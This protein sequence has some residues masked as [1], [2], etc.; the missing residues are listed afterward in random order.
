MGILDGLQTYNARNGAVRDLDQSD[1]DADAAR[2]GSLTING[3]ENPREPRA[4]D[5]RARR[6]AQQRRGVENLNRNRAAVAASGVVVRERE[7]RSYNGRPVGEVRIIRNADDPAQDNQKGLVHVL[8][9]K[10]DAHNAPVADIARAWFLE[11]EATITRGAISDVINRLRANLDGPAGVAP[12][13]PTTPAKK[14]FDKFTDIPTGYYAIR[15]ADDAE[16]I[17]FYRV[18][19]SRDER[20]IR[21]AEMASDTLYPVRPWSR[22]LTILT[23]LRASGPRDAALLF[24]QT[25]G[26]CCRCNRTLTDANSRANGIGPDCGGKAGW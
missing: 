9:R 26:R 15:D 17:H 5:G 3:G 7:E 2:L 11:R 21:V 6:S 8:L 20:Y 14:E 19:R 4:D 23:D 18:S 10:L 1:V 22:A 12:V 13:A 16:K 24:G 25:I